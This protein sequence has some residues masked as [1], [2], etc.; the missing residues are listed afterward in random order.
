M[1]TGACGVGLGRER[2]GMN[3]RNWP[4]L[5]QGVSISS[6]CTVPYFQEQNFLQY[7]YK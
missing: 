7:F 6:I 2:L 1:E 4:G 3:A 5:M